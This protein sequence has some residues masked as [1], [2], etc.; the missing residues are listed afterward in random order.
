MTSRMWQ[1]IEEGTRR[2]LTN[3]EKTEL[4]RLFLRVAGKRPKLAVLTGDY[5]NEVNSEA[6]FQGSSSS[7][8]LTGW[9]AMRVSTSRR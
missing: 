3:D 8:R 1:L 6:R 5:V 2:P 9:S 4:Q 7:M